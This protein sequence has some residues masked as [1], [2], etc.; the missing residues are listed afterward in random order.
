[1]RRILLALLLCRVAAGEERA[2]LA[3]L[4]PERTIAIAEVATLPEQ[5]PLERLFAEPD[6][7]RFLDGTKGALRTLAS[8]LGPLR[9]LGLA[10]EDLDGI[11]IDRAGIA[12]V[13][14]SCRSIRD[15]DAIARVRFA[16]GG[17]KAMKAADRLRQAA[18]SLLGVAFEAREVRGRTVW[19]GHHRGVEFALCC[20]KEEALVATRF[21]RVVETLAAL[22]GAGAAPLA[23]AERYRNAFGGF[24]EGPRGLSGFV[25]LRAA[26][27]R[28]LEAIPGG[29][30]REA[31]EASGLL[32]TE[33]L[34]F[35]DTLVGS[36]WR[37]EAAIRFPERKKLFALVD[38]GAPSDRFLPAVPADA[39]VYGSER[40]DLAAFL[41]RLE[42]ALPAAIAGEYREAIRE[43]EQAI[44]VSLRDDLGASLGTEWAGYVAPP[45][46]GGL[47]PDLAGFATLRDRARFERAVEKAVAKLNE[48]ALGRGGRA[49]LREAPFRGGTIRFLEISG[50]GGVPVG[51]APAWMVRDD[52]L[53]FGLWPQTVKHAV[54]AAAG[55][56]GAL[57]ARE[58]FR[59]LRELVPP[60]ATSYTWADLGTVAVWL[61][62]TAAPILQGV[63]SAIQDRL[64]P[65]GARI[66]FEDLP[67]G[68]TIRKHLKGAIFWFAPEERALRWGYV[69]SAGAPVAG[70]ALLV[71]AVAAAAFFL[72][73]EVEIAV[74]APAPPDLGEEEEIAR[75]EREIEE[76]RR[77]LRELE[78]R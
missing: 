29:G 70:A 54:E 58:E 53:L 51:I 3:A 5:T 52:H 64:L 41:A 27:A 11:A 75:L 31:L 72:W 48:A 6:V 4:V 20:T 21:D 59:A 40:L 1:M 57:A 55:E 30:V 2:P 37:T 67:T 56:R 15:L 63:Q 16:A 61:Y 62:N 73:S 24:A 60:N 39:I 68:A 35:A 36:R 23:A 8:G 49:T 42:A 43:M 22:D 26:S 47:L 71:P 10:P 69:S 74:E 28:I 7:R 33:S 32:E 13:D 9:A 65:L 34:A 25:D 46:V 14:F 18:E 76:L 50:P 78:G 17:E 45:P 19:V 66:P 77:M 12:L 44:G 38:P